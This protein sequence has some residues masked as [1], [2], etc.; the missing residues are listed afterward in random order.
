MIQTFNGNAPD[1]TF[2]N[3]CQWL[4]SCCNS[5]TFQHYRQQGLWDSYYVRTVTNEEKPML[6][7]VPNKN[8]SHEFKALIY[9]WTMD[10]CDLNDHLDHPNIYKIH[11]G[12]VH[13][14]ETI[15]QLATYTQYVSLGTLQFCNSALHELRPMNWTNKMEVRMTLD[16]ALG[17]ANGLKY[18]F[19]QG[20]THGNLRS[21]KV[22]LHLTNHSIDVQLKDLVSIDFSNGDTSGSYGSNQCWYAPDTSDHEGSEELTQAMNIW[23]LGMI[24]VS[25]DT[26]A[27][28]FANM[29]RHFTP[30][31]YGKEAQL[32]YYQGT[33]R[34]G[35]TFDY[36][37]LSSKKCPE[38][39]KYLIKC[40]LTVD[41]VERPS[42]EWI[43]RYLQYFRNP[44]QLIDENFKE[45]LIATV[46][47]P[48]RYTP[49]LQNNYESFM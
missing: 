33:P 30:P 3:Y 43:I 18:L 10:E 39:Y 1:D 46:F 22:L 25:L 49:F 20:L 34:R 6:C 40:C 2:D 29:H 7:T 26:H 36:N 9:S 4:L 24:L 32:K 35:Y 23:G 42:I 15:N 17:V 12:Y 13:H 27:E 8:L 5:S 41:P 28:P 21:S 44:T 19:D 16:I 31:L 48:D 37:D 45:E 38:W 47:H 14:T 11:T